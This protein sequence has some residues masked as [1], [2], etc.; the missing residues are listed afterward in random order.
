MA[1]SIRRTF[2]IL[3]L[4]V[5]VFSCKSVTDKAAKDIPTRSPV[6][7]ETI[8]SFFELVSD[9]NIDSIEVIDRI[10]YKIAEENDSLRYIPYRN[11]YEDRAFI[12]SSAKK[13]VFNTFQRV[14]LF[15]EDKLLNGV[16]YSVFR[17]DIHNKKRLDFS[18]EPHPTLKWIFVVRFRSQE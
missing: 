6:N 1:W 9:F 16:L 12:F 18:I 4:S 8:D 10:G 15:E 3:S 14:P 7:E 2:I 13:T 5:F 11:N 17:K